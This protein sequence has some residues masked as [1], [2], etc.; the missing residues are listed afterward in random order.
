MTIYEKP[1][2]NII[3][4]SEKWKAVL[5]TEKSAGMPILSTSVQRSTGSP[6][7]CN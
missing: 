5:E 2:I 3:L 1:A 7:H 6:S 4:N